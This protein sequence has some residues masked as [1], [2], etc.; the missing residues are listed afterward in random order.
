[1][2]SAQKED[3]DMRICKN[4]LSF[5][6]CTAL[7]ALFG[8]GIA[9]G[10]PTPIL[11]YDSAGGTG[12]LPQ[13]GDGWTLNDPDGAGTVLSATLD[14]G[15]GGLVFVDGDGAGAVGDDPA[16]HDIYYEHAGLA[17][18]SASGWTVVIR[19]KTITA[20][21]VDRGGTCFAY[22]PTNVL[23]GQQGLAMG[24]HTSGT[25]REYLADARSEKRFTSSAD[26]FNWH[27]YRVVY[28]AGGIP[29]YTS[30]PIGVFIDE[31]G[32]QFLTHL[33]AGTLSRN[34]DQDYFRFG[35][36]TTSQAINGEFVVDW[37][38]VYG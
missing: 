14:A 23:E 37:V 24:R 36:H 8:P 31:D 34:P 18:D 35:L 17:P 38:R 19:C 3:D 13:P 21:S 22:N 2:Q 4:L 28:N 15:E 11:E 9:F 27:T 26:L 32:G 7:L 20:T 1:V 10:Q 25:F 6:L 16:T 30:N 33:S 5:G 12:A 29:G